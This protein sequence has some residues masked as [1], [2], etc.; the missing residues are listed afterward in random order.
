MWFSVVGLKKAL[1][2]MLIAVTCGTAMPAQAKDLNA[3]AVLFDIEP[4][5]RFPF[6]SGI[7]EGLGYARFRA[8]GNTTD[9]MACIYH[10]LYDNILAAFA[11]FQDRT[12]GAIIA[13][14]V[15]R[16]CGA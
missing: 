12:P 11:K 13:A 7:I 9:G 6:I 8:D 5:D 3:G 16:R 14:L 1:G 15:Q 10:W 2:A 4:S